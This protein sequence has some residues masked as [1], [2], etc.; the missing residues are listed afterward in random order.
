MATP[1]GTA[2]IVMSSVSATV[3]KMAGKTPPAVMPSRGAALETNSQLSV[4]DPPMTT[5]RTMMASITRMTTTA[6][7]DATA[8]ARSPCRTPADEPAVRTAGAVVTALI[9]AVP[10]WRRMPCTMRSP[11]KFTTKVARKSIAPSAKRTS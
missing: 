11:A 3:P 4:R 5:S 7:A 6:A 10:S 1:A 8:R 9:W 2:A